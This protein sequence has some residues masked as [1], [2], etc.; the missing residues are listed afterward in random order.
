MFAVRVCCFCL[1]SQ[2]GKCT[3]KQEQKWVWVVTKG[4]GVNENDGAENNDVNTGE[5]TYAAREHS[6]VDRKGKIPGGSNHIPLAE[7]HSFVILQSKHLGCNCA[8]ESH[9]EYDIS[10]LLHFILSE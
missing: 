3:G 6:E 10:T 4:L 7:R 1:C 9:R 2:G 5:S 8:L